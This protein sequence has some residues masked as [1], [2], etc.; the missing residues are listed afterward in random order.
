MV[1]GFTAKALRCEGAQGNSVT[2]RLRAFAVKPIY[3]PKS[4]IVILLLILLPQSP[5]QG[6]RIIPVI[7]F[8]S[9]DLLD[10]NPR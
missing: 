7:I 6:R 9:D 10:F 1:E 5:R 2:W 3:S 8:G 4:L